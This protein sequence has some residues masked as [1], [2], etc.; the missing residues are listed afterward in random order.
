MTQRFKKLIVALL[1]GLIIV[2][3]VLVSAQ[4]NSTN[5]SITVPQYQ[6][7]DTSLST[8]LCTPSTNTADSHALEKCINKLYRFG[9]SFGAISLVFFLVFAGYMYITGGE[10]GKSKAKG[11]LSNAFIGMGLLLAS[12]L[13]L[14]FISP[15]LVIFKPIQPPI[16]GAED[17]PSCDQIGFKAGCEIDDFLAQT[18]LP[19]TSGCKTKFA[20]QQ[21]AE[22]NLSTFSVQAWGLGGVTK[23]FNVTVQKCLVEKT[24]AVFAQIYAAS[25]K[26]PIKNIGG[27]AWRMNV[28]GTAPSTHSYGLTLDINWEENYF[29]SSKLTVGKYW[30]PCPGN[31]CDPY[32][33]PASSS[34][35]TMLKAAG[36][37]WG[38]EWNSKKDYMHFSC[39][40]S[41]YGHCF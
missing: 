28:E 10:G 11:I 29:I 41:E 21:E 36:F 25:D 8:Y 23:S 6:G 3:P 24:K 1:F 33:L 40:P 19:S 27:Y 32:S 17:I 31:G 5:S 38:G 18:N 37:G 4:A 34:V 14:S 30:K 12:Y 39:H 26:Q 15:S 13:I 2:N 20:T 22:Q 7:V 35:V 16:F 9:I